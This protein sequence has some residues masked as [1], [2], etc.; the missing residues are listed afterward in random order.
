MNDKVYYNS[1][2]PVCKAGIENQQRQMQ[3]CEINHIEWIDIHTNPQTIT[4]LGH[5][6]EELRERL[7]IRD[8][9]GELHI[10][11][12]ALIRLWQQTPHQ[13]WLAAVVQLPLI[14]S[15]ARLA[16]NGFA[17]LLYGY[18]RILKHW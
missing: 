15:L 5:S 9:N 8:G 14:H 16:Y 10:G 13:R 3:Q 1:G 17:K 6:L 18:N 4:E 7:H 12:D 11:I 2:C